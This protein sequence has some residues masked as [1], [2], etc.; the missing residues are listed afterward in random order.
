MPPWPRGSSPAA[1]LA[2]PVPARPCPGPPRSRSSSRRRRSDEAVGRARR[3]GPVLRSW[4]LVVASAE[5]GGC[6]PPLRRTVL[7]KA[8]LQ[9]PGWSPGAPAELSRSALRPAGSEVPGQSR[10]IA[11]RS[12]DGGGPAGGM[13]NARRHSCR[14]VDEPGLAPRRSPRKSGGNVGCAWRCHGAGGCRGIGKNPERGRGACHAGRPGRHNRRRARPAPK[15]GFSSTPRPGMMAGNDGVCP[16][17]R[18]GS[19]PEK[20]PTAPTS[21]VAIMEDATPSALVGPGRTAGPRD[22]PVASS[23]LD[24]GRCR[25]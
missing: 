15:L 6:K 11:C 16:T 14:E 23:G 9:P 8:R 2:A 1:R 3:S 25:S 18:G 17:S 4:S 22:R 10:R 24:A 21:A 7:S 13:G 12:S 19:A 5:W 20:R